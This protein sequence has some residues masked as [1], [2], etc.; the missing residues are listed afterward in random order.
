MKVTIRSSV[1]DFVIRDLDNREMVPRVNDTIYVDEIRY[2]VQQL[3]WNDL[4]TE[5]EVLVREGR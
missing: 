4:L 3:T 1:T 2:T 5:V